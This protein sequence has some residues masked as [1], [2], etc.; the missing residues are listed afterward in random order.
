MGLMS[1]TP[2]E[3]KQALLLLLNAYRAQDVRDERSWR[4]ILEFIDREPLA[5]YR[6]TVEGHLT[7]SAWIVNRTGDRVLLMHHRKLN[8]W[9]QPGGHADGDWDL[10][11]VAFREASE[12]TGLSSLEIQAEKVFDVDVH[13][14]PAY[15]NV[16]AHRHF[17][18]RFVCVADDEEP[19]VQSSESY[20]IAWVAIEAIERYTTEESI[21][22]MKGKWLQGS[23]VP[24]LA[25]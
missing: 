11:F 21:L 6:E 3:P 9:I 5:A 1:D 8:K 15:K 10:P 17:D 7:A 14:I 18:L 24:H 4:A 22:R 2:T 13:A 19:I 23:F 12:E 25:R 20:A 16:A